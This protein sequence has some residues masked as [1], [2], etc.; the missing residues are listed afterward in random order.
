LF[1][2]DFD[3]ALTKQFVRAWTE[4]DASRPVLILTTSRPEVADSV[5]AD[6][7]AIV[8]RRPVW[9]WVLLAAIRSAISELAETKSARLPK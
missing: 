7:R 5:R 8:L 3:A 9:G 2:D 1:G 6:N 4:A